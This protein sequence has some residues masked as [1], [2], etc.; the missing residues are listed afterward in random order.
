MPEYIYNKNRWD[1]KFHEVH[2]KSCNYKPR[3]ENQVDLGWHPNC[4]EA[5]K[6]AVRR[7]NEHDFDGCKYCC[8]DCH[9]G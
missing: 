3:L 5:I 8:P 7:T 2:T 6:E 1:G 4:K 9:S